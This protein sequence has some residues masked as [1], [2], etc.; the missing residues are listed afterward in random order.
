[1][2]S[3]SWLAAAS[4]DAL[5]SAA[6]A[7]PALAAPAAAV[8]AARAPAVAVAGPRLVPDRQATLVQE[9]LDVMAA[10]LK[11]ARTDI[12]RRSDHAFY[13][14]L[15]LGIL[16][17]LSVIAGASLALADVVAVGIASGVG[18]VM[19]GLGSG[20]SY[21]MYLQENSNLQATIRDLRAMETARFGLLAV[22]GVTD[23]AIRNGII[24]DLVDRLNSKDRAPSAG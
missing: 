23:E 12:R 1:M 16:A 14:A 6:L 18:G 4:A 5:P 17:A 15:A 24:R 19:S 2:P 20:M 22:A 21:K 8:V 13:A 7:A 9:W 3:L 11:E 10:D